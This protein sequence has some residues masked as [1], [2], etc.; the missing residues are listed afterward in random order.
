MRGNLTAHSAWPARLTRGNNLH[1]RRSFHNRPPIHPPRT[2][3]TR[4]NAPRTDN[5]SRA[6]EKSHAT[7]TRAQQKHNTCHFRWHLSTAKATPQ[8]MAV[9]NHLHHAQLRRNDLEIWDFSERTLP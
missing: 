3:Q 6:Q 5:F 1:A 9:S 8:G 2:Q 4:D 7:Q